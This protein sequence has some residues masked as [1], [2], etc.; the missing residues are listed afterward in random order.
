MIPL[1]KMLGLLQLIRPI[2]CT[3]MG[4]A[5]LIG[6]LL[7]GIRLFD[8]NEYFIAPLLGFITAF[9]FTGAAMA[10]NDYYDREIDAI[11]EPNRP[12]PSGLIK[13]SEAL[14]LVSFLVAIGLIAA[15][16]T[17]I[18]C[19]IISLFAL[20]IFMAYSTK[21]KRTGLLGN[22]LV[23]TCVAIPFIY[24]SFTISNEI[25][26]NAILFS[27]LAFLSNTGREITKGIADIEGDRSRNIRTI[28]AIQGA[29][30][31]AIMASA[32]YILAV[33]L[34]ILPWAWG[35]VSIWYVPPIII[36]DTGFILTSILL[37]RDHSRDNA[38]RIKKMVLIWM[39]AG[40][41]S[42]VLGI[43]A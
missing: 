24:G 16:F 8:L 21:G 33:I 22:F 14:T 30:K 27:I 31:A 18:L 20:V 36:T 26:L 5:T 4:F 19:L 23:S 12:I 34:S 37:I 3:M 35:L 38:K 2:N 10:I 41:I 40:L 1:N 6:V 9:T 28:A 17:S 39:I 15:F 25:K 32:F 29:H 11:N 7:S 42:F 43:M 13:P